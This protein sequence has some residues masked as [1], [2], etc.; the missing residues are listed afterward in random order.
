M[1]NRR[2]YDVVPEEQYY[3]DIMAEFKKEFPHMSDS[4][5]NLLSIIARI[6]ARNEN[7]RDYDRVTA[8]SDAYVATATG[9]HLSKAVR[10]AG[11]SRLSGTRAIGKVTITKDTDLSQAIIPPSMAIK[12]G[13][14]VY[15]TTNADA[16]ILNSPTIELEIISSSVG[17]VNNISTG[18]KFDTVLNIK[19]IKSVVASTDILGGTDIESDANLRDRY[20]R[21]MNSYSNSSLRGIIDKVSAID[22]VYMVSGD[23]NNKDVEENGLLP[24]SFIIYVAGGKD[25]DVAEVIMTSKPAGIQMNGDITKTVVVSGKEHPIKFSRFKSQA[26]YFNLE[27]AIDKS[28]SSPDFVDNIKKVIVDFTNSTSKIVGYELS[29]HISQEIAEVRGVRSLKFGTS[30]NP[31]SSN[32]LVAPSGLNFTTDSKKINI[33]VI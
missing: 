15:V 4:P 19:G 24:H 32:D 3:D 1:I 29:N 27:V 11:I 18:S 14:N 33:V 12:S 26:V 21:R 9:M 8:Y 7:A 16:I 13:N 10:T 31:Q 20:F 28:I 6:I 17:V 2:G 22:E 23:E 5:S 25:Q 30:D